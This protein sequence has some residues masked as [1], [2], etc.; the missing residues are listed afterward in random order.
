MR[1]L[2]YALN[3]VT[4]AALPQLG[5]NLERLLPMAHPATAVAEVDD[6]PHLPVPPVPR[7]KLLAGAGQHRRS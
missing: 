4:L 5:A 6:V 3:P 1:R 2:F 7:R